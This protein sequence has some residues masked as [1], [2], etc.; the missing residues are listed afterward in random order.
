MAEPESLNTPP[1]IYK[2]EGIGQSCFPS[3]LDRSLIDAWVKTDD[4]ESFLYA[5]RIIKEEGMF[6]GGSA[7]TVVLGAFRYLKENGLHNNANLRLGI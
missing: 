5:K 7:G 4:E 1:K 6:V 3:V 2:I